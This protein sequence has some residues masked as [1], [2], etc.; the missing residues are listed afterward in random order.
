MVPKERVSD[1]VC[2]RWRDPLTNLRETSAEPLVES[3]MKDATIDCP[4]CNRLL[5]VT[6]SVRQ[7]LHNRKNH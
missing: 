2:S 5:P 3:K 6:S 4:E 1:L 7:D